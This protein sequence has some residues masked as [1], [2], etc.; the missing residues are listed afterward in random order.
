MMEWCR[1]NARETTD[2]LSQ[3]YRVQPL[4]GFARTVRWWVKPKFPTHYVVGDASFHADPTLIERGSSRKL[5]APMRAHRARVGSVEPADEA[6][7][8]KNPRGDK[9]PHD[10]DEST[11]T[12]TFERTLSFWDAGIAPERLVDINRHD[13]SIVDAEVVGDDGNEEIVLEFEVER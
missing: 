6:M 3:N 9:S 12:E 1:F 2:F 13:I 4:R 7:S 11:T 8:D 10:A 5:R